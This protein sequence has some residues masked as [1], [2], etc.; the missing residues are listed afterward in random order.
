[1]R[2]RRSRRPPRRTRGTL[3][4]APLGRAYRLTLPVQGKMVSDLFVPDYGRLTGTL[5]VDAPLSAN[6]VRTAVPYSAIDPATEY[7]SPAEAAAAPEIGDGTQ[8][9]RITHDGTASHSVTFGGFDVQVLSRARREGAVRPPD[10]GELGWKDTLRVDPLESVLVAMRPVLA[11]VPFGLPASGRPLDITRPLGAEGP[12][13]QLD[14][15]TAEPLQPP[16]VNAAADFSFEMRWGIHLVGGQESHTTRP[17]VLQGTAA[18]P[19]GVT[20]AAGDGGVVISWT[21]PLFPPPVVGY[22]IQRAADEGF[23]E[24]VAPL[25]PSGADASFTDTG[26]SPGAKYFYRVRTVSSAGWS[27]WSPAAEVDVP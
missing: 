22:E 27:P 6:G 24:G 11:G 3:T 23:G 15:L 16:V 17:V 2:T 21:P 12:F 8:I 18:A 25:A 20:A 9:W 10:P 4:F 13:T 14:Q 26:A 1:M 19:T 5:G 7:L